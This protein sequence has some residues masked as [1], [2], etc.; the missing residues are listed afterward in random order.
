[1]TA[2]G[3]GVDSQV[4]EDAATGSVGDDE[5]VRFELHQRPRDRRDHD[6]G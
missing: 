1:M 2:K 6:A 3:H 4:Y 5:G